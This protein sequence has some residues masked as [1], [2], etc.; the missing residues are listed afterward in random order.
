MAK[1]INKVVLSTF[2]NNLPG[3]MRTQSQDTKI[4]V[5]TISGWKNKKHTPR[6]DSL[7]IFIKE[8]SKKL[9]LEQKMKISNIIMEAVNIDIK[10]RIADS[11]RREAEENFEEFI[12]YMLK[13]YGVRKNYDFNFL[14]YEVEKI[15]EIIFLKMNQWIEGINGISI[16][17]KTYNNATYFNIRL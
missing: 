9:S 14:D 2:L 6:E 1:E 12:N 10:G 15:N 7:D 16:G 17:K 11:F 8:I 4:G 5:G 13:E 3:S